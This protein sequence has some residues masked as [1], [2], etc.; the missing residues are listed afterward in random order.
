MKNQEL[1]LP[2]HEADVV[3]AMLI[4]AMDYN[5]SVEITLSFANICTE[6]K[7]KT[8]SDYAECSF[9]AIGEWIK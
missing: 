4:V 6:K 3:S 7:P 2:K 1:V 5:L 8:V 9:L